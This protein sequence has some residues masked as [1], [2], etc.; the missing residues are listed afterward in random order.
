MTASVKSSYIFKHTKIMFTVIIKY[1][2][3]SS[4]K[5]C[6]EFDQSYRH[7]VLVS[8]MLN[9]RL[10]VVIEQITVCLNIT[11]ELEGMANNINS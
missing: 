1:N 11:V 5:H 4:T 10:G 7:Q 3:R 8:C 6:I 2:K 9:V